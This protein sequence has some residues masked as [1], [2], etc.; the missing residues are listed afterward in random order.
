MCLIEIPVFY[1]LQLYDSPLI[2]NYHPLLWPS[3]TL[4]VAKD[5]LVKIAGCVHISSKPTTQINTFK[6]AV[7]VIIITNTCCVFLLLFLFFVL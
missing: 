2:F 4:D 5:E 3:L 1:S 7:H 6:P